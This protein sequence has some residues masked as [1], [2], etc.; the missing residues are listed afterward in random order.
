MRQTTRL[1]TLLV[2]LFAAA[3][4]AWAQLIYPKY[5]VVDLTDGSYNYTNE[6]PVLDHAGCRKDELWLRF[7][8]AGTFTMGS[9]TDEPGYLDDENQ[10]QVTLTKPYYIGIFECTQ[11]QWEMVMSK[12]WTES[13]QP[14]TR[15]SWFNVEGWQTR[16]VEKVSYKYIRGGEDGNGWPDSDGVDANSFMGLL[17]TATG[18]TFDLPTEA[19]WEYACRAGE[20]GP[21][22]TGAELTDDNMALA[23]R[24]RGNSGYVN[25][26]EDD[27]SIMNWSP[28]QG[29]AMV[30]SYAP[31]SW[32]L[33]DMHGNVFEWCLDWNYS[34]PYETGTDGNPIEDPVGASYD[35]EYGDSRAIRGGSWCSPASECRSGHRSTTY[36]V[37]TEANHGFRIVC[38]TLPDANKEYTV[39]ITGGTTNKAKA[40]PGETVTITANAPAAGMVFDNWIGGDDLTFTDVNAGEWT[41]TMP[42][43]NVHLSSVYTAFTPTNTVNLNDGTKNPTT[44]Q[45]KVGTGD[46][47]NLPLQ[48]VT[49]GQ[50]VTLK[51]SGD[52]EVKSITATEVTSGN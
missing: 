5:L 19:Q 20:S 34:E 32:G 7:I 30:G 35:S 11:Y 50:T 2:L 3:T 17:R 42:V 25:G 31:N 43:R 44:W 45:G 46:F 38:L 28:E 16:P 14:S 24:Y 8:P 23:G 41:F 6:G 33:Y 4:G 12:H 47:G 49:E 51:Y 9:A 40:K 15:P 39:Q 18:L 27:P 13:T 21:L 36:Y 52:R 10:H 48:G 29:T 22:N 26:C 37:A 1:L